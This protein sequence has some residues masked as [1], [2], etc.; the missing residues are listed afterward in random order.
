ML[1][2]SGEMFFD[3]RGQDGAAPPVEFDTGMG[4]V[5]E[6]LDVSVRLMTPGELAR[7][8]A[9]ARSADAWA[10]NLGTCTGSRKTIR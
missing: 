1:A 10:S 5:P 9:T 6:G 8:R 4:L 2:E 7:I 3:T